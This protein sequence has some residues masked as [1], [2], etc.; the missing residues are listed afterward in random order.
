LNVARFREK[1]G[2]E[3]AESFL[4]Q[5]N[6]R[7]NAG[8]FIWTIP[9]ILSAFERH[10]PALAD[11]VARIHGGANFHRLLRDV[12]PTLPK[13]SIDYSVMEKVRRVLTVEASFDWDDVG[14][15]VAAAKYLASDPAHNCANT[16]VK[17]VKAS[18]NIVFCSGKKLVGLIGVNDLIVVQ[19]EDALL[20]CN[21]HDAE[22]IK[23]LV[24]QIPAELQ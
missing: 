21:R 7:W 3:L 12:F 18:N 11:F 24:T 1:P 17:V 13:I 16:A 10:A 15:W 20:V 22:K 14:S 8:M 19:T 2:V 4:Q 6:F 5:G 23:E 9:A